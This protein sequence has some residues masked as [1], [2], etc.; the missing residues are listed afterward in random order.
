[1]PAKKWYKKNI[2]SEINCRWEEGL[3]LFEHHISKELPGLRGAARKTLGS[4]RAAIEA[5]G[6]NYEEIL[7]KG[8]KS[9][10]KNLSKY[11]KELVKGLILM[12]LQ[13]GED[14]SP[15]GLNERHAG[16]MSSIRKRLFKTM[17]DCYRF[18]GIDPKDVRRDA[19]WT[20]WIENPE[21]VLEQLRELYDQ[22]HPLNSSYI[23]GYRATLAQA[24]VRY[25]GTFDNALIT[26]GFDPKEIRLDVNT[27]KA[28]GDAFDLT[29]IE[30]FEILQP[31]WEK[32]PIRIIDGHRFKPDII[33]DE[34][35]WADF[36]LT[37]YGKS[38]DSTI[39]KYSPYCN[40]IIIIYLR[41]RKRTYEGN[42]EFVSIYNFIPENPPQK[43][44]EIKKKFDELAKAPDIPVN[45]SGWAV[46]WTKAKIVEILK[47]SSPEQPNE[48][49]NTLNRNSLR[50]AAIRIF[51]N[52]SVALKAAG[53]DH[54]S[55]LKT[56]Y[57]YPKEE[58]DRDITSLIKSGER[59]NTLYVYQNHSSLYSGA[60]RAYGS[61]RAALTAFGI[62]YASV[63]RKSAGATERATQY[64]VDGIKASFSSRELVKML[65]LD[66]NH[67]YFYLLFRKLAV[68]KI[69]ILK[70]GRIQGVKLRRVKWRQLFGKTITRQN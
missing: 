17:D 30:L 15:S 4:W 39:N 29:C 38:V 46:K 13:R 34:R 36:K 52:W 48:R 60:Q 22:G 19:A 25:Y 1:M 63:D 32:K 42:V 26:A 44:I 6:L 57:R 10:S 16:M 21:L 24:M 55:T 18:C 11:T 43:I 47:N 61:W 58:I 12:D 50:L 14:I 66:V 28:I 68:N 51:G 2:I 5:A 69:N 23:N 41:G 31:S 49:W 35:T 62:D 37:S 64:T 33:I 45:W 70:D 20:K 27:A 54:Q 9:K 53:I 59:L 7:A 3:P 65:D 67:R 8:R 56:R 40:K